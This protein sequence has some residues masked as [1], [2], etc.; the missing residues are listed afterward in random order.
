MHKE[1]KSVPFPRIM[2]RKLMVRA[3]RQ[4]ILLILR[5]TQN[6]QLL[7]NFLMSQVYMKRGQISTNQRGQVSIISFCTG[8][9]PTGLCNDAIL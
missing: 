9:H 7:Q 4:N 2:K 8:A 5:P 1:F 3:F 6:F